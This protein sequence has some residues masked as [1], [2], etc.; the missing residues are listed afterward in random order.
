[1]SRPLAV[2][3]P[4]PG[5]T[6]TAARITAAGHQPL[7]VPLFHVEQRHWPPVAASD[8]DALVLT[9]ANTVR[10]AGPQLA[11]L[12]MLPV[13]AI[14]EA[15]A[16]AAAGSGLTVVRTGTEGAET[17]L[18]T[19][20]E[21]GVRRALWL[22]GESLRLSEHPAVSRTVAVYA[23]TALAPPLDAVRRLAGSVALAHSPRA[24]ERLRHVLAE[25]GV[26]P[27]ALRLAAISPAAARA[28]GDGWDA[29]AV[30]PRPSDPA[31]VDAAIRLAD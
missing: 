2:L 7:R 25:A 24:A 22:G 17:L 9:S 16:R 26:P 4:E 31:L 10:H 19:A 3:R 12:A 15:T 20:L 28:G 6:A 8:H 5:A 23:S 18:D 11:G 29:V 1:M 30:A 13:W 14:G 27:S 21:A